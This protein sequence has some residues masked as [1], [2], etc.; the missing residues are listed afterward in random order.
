M[1]VGLWGVGWVGGILVAEGAS[2]GGGVSDV[3][4]RRRSHFV[5]MGDRH[6][7]TFDIDE[8]RGPFALFAYD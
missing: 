7:A 8:T 4:P 6:L 1:R 3:T 5:C 2:G